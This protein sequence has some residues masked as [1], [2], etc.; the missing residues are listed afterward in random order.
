MVMTSTI[1]HNGHWYPW[2]RFRFTKRQATRLRLIDAVCLFF[3]TA[4]L[5]DTTYHNLCKNR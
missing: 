4:E 2:R 3:G 5:S 1:A